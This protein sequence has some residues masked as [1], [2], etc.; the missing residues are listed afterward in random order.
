MKSLKYIFVL[1]LACITPTLLF[2]KVE[3]WDTFSK[4]QA[5]QQQSKRT[6]HIVIIR[7]EN[8]PGKAINIYIDGEYVSS[9]L[10]GAYT[11]E[12]VC[13]GKHRVS[14]AYTNVAT[15]YKEKYKGGEWIKFK[16]SQ[17]HV[18][19]LQKEGNKL[20]FT[21]LKENNISKLLKKYT[22]KQTHTISRLSKKKCTEVVE[23]KRK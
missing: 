12:V 20:H 5:T 13:T 1:C 23:S 4:Q 6:A 10:P 11:E 8:L 7:P 21:H 16:S 15:R 22:K 18:Y 19:M 2:A 17:K 3:D 14:L 9:L